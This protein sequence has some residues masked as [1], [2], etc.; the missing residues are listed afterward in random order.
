MD[1]EAAGD[2]QVDGDAAAVRCRQTIQL[3]DERGSMPAAK[4]DV[5]IKLRRS[6]DGWVIEAIQ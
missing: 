6:A 1:L 4:S 2:P 3:R 5:L